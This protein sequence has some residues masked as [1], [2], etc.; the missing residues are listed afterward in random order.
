MD[1][2]AYLMVGDEAELL[3]F[4]LTRERT[5]LLILV[6]ESTSGSTRITHTMATTIIVTD[7]TIMINSLTL[8]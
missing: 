6:I 5:R 1:E 7:T 4:A 3:K 8:S 2:F